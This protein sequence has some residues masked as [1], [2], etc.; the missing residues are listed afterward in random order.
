[1]ESCSLFLRSKGP[2]PQL[3]LF[4]KE[5]KH[6]PQVIQFVTFL[7]WW[8]RDPFQRLSDLQLGD[9]RVTKNHLALF[10]SLFSSSPFLHH[11]PPRFGCHHGGSLVFGSDDARFSS[12][13]WQLGSGSAFQRLW[14]WLGDGL[15]RQ[16]S[17]VMQ[18]N[19]AAVWRMDGWPKRIQKLT[20][21]VVFFLGGKC[22]YMDKFLGKAKVLKNQRSRI[23][24]V[25]FL[26]FV[27]VCVFLKFFFS[28]TSTGDMFFFFLIFF[29]RG[30]LVPT[31]THRTRAEKRWP[32]GFASVNLIV[33][34]KQRIEAPNKNGVEKKPWNLETTNYAIGIQSPSE[35]GNGT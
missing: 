28:P 27:E 15:G 10:F 30:N 31:K 2:F 8:K 17:R 25:F 12:G 21:K 26:I 35:N 4:R 14:C 32:S 34:T 29:L 24:F 20:V 1:M 16:L 19:Q 6:F 23:N 7:G 3:Q 33:K 13:Q 18:W 11:H 22:V 5:P 9:K